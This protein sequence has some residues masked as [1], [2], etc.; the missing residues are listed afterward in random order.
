MNRKD[1]CKMGEIMLM[2]LRI[3]M[4]NSNPK[5]IGGIRNMRIFAFEMND[6]VRDTITGFTGVVTARCQY[7]TEENYYRVEWVDKN[8]K[9]VEV[10]FSGTRL[11]RHINR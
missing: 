1:Y 10:W 7:A 3:G 4:M 9:P 8:G 11:A 6:E 5:L 2:G